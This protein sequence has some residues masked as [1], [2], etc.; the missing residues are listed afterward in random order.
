MK[1]S[2]YLST[3]LQ[4]KA[5]VAKLGN[6]S[7]VARLMAII[8]PRRACTARVTVH[9]VVLCVCVCVCLSVS[10]LICRLALLSIR[11][12]LSPGSSCGLLAYASARRYYNFPHICG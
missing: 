3:Q 10:T 1:H 2:A 8:N 7:L 12:H 11:V 9:V 6:K 5:S 4:G